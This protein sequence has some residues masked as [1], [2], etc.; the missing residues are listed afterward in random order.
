MGKLIS[1]GEMLIDFTAVQQGRIDE[2]TNFE[3]NPGGAPANVALCAAKYGAEVIFL[4]KL[5]MD[6][7]GGYL[8]EILR[9]SGVGVSYVK[10]TTEANTPLA[11]V[12]LDTNGERE[13][14]FYRNPS[15]DLL[16]S[17]EEIDPAVFSQGDILHFCSV[18]LVDYPVKYAH[19]AAI[20]HALN[21]GAIISFDPNLRFSLWPSREELVETV[22]EFIPF[23]HILKLGEDELKVISGIDDEAD[24]VRS[25]LI[26]NVCIVLITRGKNGASA[27][28]KNIA[29]MDA[30]GAE[31][32][33]VDATGAGDTFIGTFLYQVLKSGK[34]LESIADECADYL[35]YCNR[36]AG[37]CVSR[38]GAIPA[39]P[40][41]EEVFYD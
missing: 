6:A 13:F 33:C 29:R 20:S 18:S 11:F 4:G 5:G 23:A 22:K 21:A 27:Y 32:V 25:L 35:R 38:R 34:N 15:S 24:A 31:A 3:K 16:L 8:Y 7:F 30:P 14:A 28:F 41:Y 26:G 40:S 10:R 2:V 12:S 39:L 19:K 9:Q 1:I 17:P 37:I 36:A